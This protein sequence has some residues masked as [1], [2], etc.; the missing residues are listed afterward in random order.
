MTMASVTV[1]IED[2]AR[3]APGSAAAL[4]VAGDQG[5]VSGWQLLV[6]AANGTVISVRAGQWVVR[7]AP[8]DV[9]VMDDGEFRRFFGEQGLAA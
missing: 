2:A 5:D 4:L 9:G 6:T 3:Y 1:T 8:G 7:Y